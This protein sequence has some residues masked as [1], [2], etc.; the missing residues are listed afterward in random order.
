MGKTSMPAFPATVD[1]LVRAMDAIAPLSAAEPW[2]R[3]GLHVGDPARDLAGPVLLTID[4]TEKV[5]DEAIGQGASAIVAYHPP[6]WKPL[7]RVTASTATE[8]IV[9]GAIEAGIAIHSPHTALDAAEGGVTDWLTECVAV[10][11]SGKPGEEAM[12]ADVRALAPLRVQATSQQVKLVIFTP[13]SAL[14]QLRG[15]LATAGAGQIG[16]YEVCSFASE[17]RGTFFGT[18]GT[19]PSVGESGRLEEVDEVR[20]E[21]V[22]SKHAL[23]LAVETLRQFHPYEEPAFDVYELLPKPMRGAGTGRRL[24]LDQ[25]ATIPQIGERLRAHLGVSRIKYALPDGMS[26]KTKVRRIAL[27]PGSGGDLIPTAVAEGC[28]LFVTGEMTHHAVKDANAQGLAVLLAGHTNT[29]RGYL[30]RLAAR[31]GAM[32]EGIEFPIA[33]TDADPLLVMK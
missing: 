4:L 18:D 30:P 3:V 10:K 28:E 31:L 29:E 22:C 14:V 24:V 1:G 5:L 8:R 27:V 20:L 15:A 16:A 9:R 7:E 12:T 19:D 2:D 33:M 25:P 26:D 32:I 11:A 23:P 21:M 6:I 13:R 17:G